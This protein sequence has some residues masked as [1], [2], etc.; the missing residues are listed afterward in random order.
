MTPRVWP[1]RWVRVGLAA[2]AVVVAVLVVS[3]VVASRP[4]PPLEPG[5]MSRITVAAQVDTEPSAVAVANRGDDVVAAWNEGGVTR[6]VLSRNRGRT[7]SAPEIVRADDGQG[8]HAE[9]LDV[10]FEPQTTYDAAPWRWFLPSAPHVSRTMSGWS[11]V[12][13]SDP[14]RVRVTPPRSLTDVPSQVV[15][16]PRIAARPIGAGLDAP[17]G[18]L[19]VAWIEPDPVRLTMHRYEL[20]GAAHHAS[21]TSDIPW[22]VAKAQGPGAR[23]VG[24]AAASATGAFVAWV[25]WTGEASALR[26]REIA[27][28]ELCTPESL[29]GSGTALPG[30]D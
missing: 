18:A 9:M 17:Q 25:E 29:V 10:R 4:A 16:R 3:H 13:T 20:T 8:D 2:S 24:A 19:F 26:V 11:V 28:D 23:I 21:G 22:I 14:R 1:Q 12:A 30:R 6:L 27:F 7:F 5:G 15:V